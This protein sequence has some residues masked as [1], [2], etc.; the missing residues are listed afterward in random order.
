MEMNA[1]QMFN[2]LG[3]YKKDVGYS[4]ILCYEKDVSIPDVPN[5]IGLQFVLSQEYVSIYSHVG[6]KYEPGMERCYSYGAF[7]GLDVDLLRAIEHQM[8]EL[9]WIKE[10]TCENLSE[11]DTI[12][13]FECSN[14]GIVLGEYQEIE[15]DEDFGD[16]Y[17]YQYRLRYCPN[18][19]RKIIN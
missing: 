19:G 3:Y 10:E 17:T 12:D 6:G 1:E 15:T 16:K 11:Y 9:G 2:A 8:R 13:E 14:C 7:N 5:Y 4:N 18:C